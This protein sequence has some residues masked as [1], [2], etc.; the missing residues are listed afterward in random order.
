MPATTI[1]GSR[2]LSPISCCSPERTSGTWK[3]CNAPTRS[4]TWTPFQGGDPPQQRDGLEGGHR[5]QSAVHVAVLVLV[6]LRA[7]DVPLLA[8]L[9]RPRQVRQPAAAAADDDDVDD[10]LSVGHL[11]PDGFVDEGVGNDCDDRDR[12]GR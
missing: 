8:L 1:R 10:R 4:N 9:G 11:L 5:S 2:H 7:V 12:E 3:A 6:D